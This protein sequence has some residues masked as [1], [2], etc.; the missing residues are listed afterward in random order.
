MRVAIDAGPTVDRDHHRRAALG[1]R[2]LRVVSEEHRAADR[3]LG[4]AGSGCAVP[5]RTRDRAAQVVRGCRLLRMVFVVAYVVDVGVV[6]DVP[7]GRSAV[8]PDWLAL[9]GDEVLLVCF[10]K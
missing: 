2:Q 10:E 5:R 9:R 8:R 6:V 1:E 7:D 4:V 3:D